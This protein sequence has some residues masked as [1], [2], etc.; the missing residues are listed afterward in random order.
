MSTCVTAEVRVSVTVLPEMA[1]PP[2]ATRRRA[3]FTVTRKAPGD[4]SEPVSRV[5]VK[6]IVSAFPCTVALSKCSGNWPRSTSRSE[7]FWFAEN[8]RLAMAAPILFPPLE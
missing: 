8:T 2:E 3:P 6:V 7:T 1:T 5:S 4:G